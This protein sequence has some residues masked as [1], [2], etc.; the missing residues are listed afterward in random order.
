M[1]YTIYDTGEGAPKKPS[2]MSI[3]VGVVKSHCDLLMQ[4]K[5]QVRIPGAGIDVW[6]RV[7]GAGGGNG[8]GFMF[9]PQPDDEVLVA[10]SDED[11]RDASIIQGYW[12][13]LN[14]LPASTPAETIAKR[15]LRTGLTP[16]LGHEI[17]MDDV[18]QTI[19]ITASTG[20]KI[21]MSPTGINLQANANT[22]IDM[23]AS[24]GV[25]P[26]VAKVTV[27]PTSITITPT[28]VEIAAATTISFKAAS[29]DLNATNV[30]IRGVKLSL[31]S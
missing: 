22:S 8:R 19:T 23:T 25:G 17:D 30:S 16:V 31:N 20:Q 7:G 11:P 24:P 1:P 12:S 21:T 27:G 15:K 13:T 10:F 26:G 2:G 9:F 28:G 14:S 3:A 29:I 18:T 5:V 6:A 4:G